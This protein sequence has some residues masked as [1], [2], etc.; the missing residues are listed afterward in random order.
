MKPF[1]IVNGDDG[2][3]IYIFFNFAQDGS[4]DINAYDDDGKCVKLFISTKPCPYQ[5]IPTKV[6]F[7]LQFLQHASF[8]FFVFGS[9][10]LLVQDVRTLF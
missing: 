3:V 5:S 7:P 2:L 9:Y 8:W 6:H 1:V 10:S 4:L